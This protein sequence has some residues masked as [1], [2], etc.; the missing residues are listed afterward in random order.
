MEETKRGD[1]LHC[2]RC[3]NKK[4]GG[5]GWYQRHEFPPERC[6]DCNSPGWNKERIRPATVQK[7]RKDD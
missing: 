4:R 5:K 2:L 6:P 7:I 1:L 3:Q